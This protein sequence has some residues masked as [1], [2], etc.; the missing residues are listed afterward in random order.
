MIIKFTSNNDFDFQCASSRLLR[1]VRKDLIK[2]ASKEE[3]FKDFYENK[4]SD[5]NQELLHLIAVGAYEGTG[6]NRNGDAF[7]EDD[8]IKN[9]KYFSKSNRAVH[10]HHKNKPSDPKFGN[11]KAAAYNKRMRRIE[12]II[13]LDKDKCSDILHEQETTGNTNWSMASKQA[14]DICSWCKHE[15]KTDK[16]RCDHIPAHLGEINKEG[17]MCGM[18]NPDPRWFEISYVKRPA[19]RIGMSLGKVA[20]AVAR[21]MSTSDYLN[22]YGDLYI[23]DDILISKKAE[24]KRELLTKLAELEKHVEAVTKGSPITRKD[25]FIKEHGHKLKHTS[26]IDYTSMD[27][28]R[29]MEPSLVLK[30]LADNGII[31]S[32][33]DFSRYLFDNRVDKSRVEG[34]KSHL[35]NIYNKIN[36]EDA[37]KTVNDEKFEPSHHGTVPEELKKTVKGL[38]E[39]HSLESGPAMRRMMMI[40]INMSGQHQTEP[41]KEACDLEFAKTYANYKLAAL[42]YLNEQ[43]KLDDELM[44]NALLQNR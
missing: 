36:D 9:H 22:I 8:C 13:G 1:D 32:P 4:K 26:N 12:L 41:T 35:P 28:L 29:K 44:L 7:L 23:P 42:N 30:T 39:G 5:P 20:S 34:M 16:D 6:Y 38:H 19:D 33:E 24:D 15:A 18:L 27:S 25:K 17:E 2:R 14:K 21:P 10:R 40:V 37:G 31:F 3:L 43:G 11:I